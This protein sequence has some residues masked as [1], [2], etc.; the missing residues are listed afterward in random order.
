MA[1][2]FLKP[3][4]APGS[5]SRERLGLEKSFLI[6]SLFPLPFCLLSNSCPPPTPPLFCRAEGGRGFHM[7]LCYRR[8]ADHLPIT[9]PL[10]P[11]PPT[12]RAPKLDTFPLCS[13]TSPSPPPLTEQS[14][15]KLFHALSGRGAPGN[16]SLFRPFVGAPQDRPA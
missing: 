5:C 11:Y 3:L 1:G 12:P 2:I 9:P 16:G 6:S 15:I 13:Q 4:C 14:F 7:F 10:F 8:A